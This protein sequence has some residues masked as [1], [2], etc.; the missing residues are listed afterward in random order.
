MDD[1]ILKETL[2]NSGKVEFKYE[3]R[4]K[5]SR[6]FT[7]DCMYLEYGQNVESVPKSVLNICFV[8][9][10][11]PLIWLT[12]TVLWVDE[13]DRTFYDCVLRLKNAYQELYPQ[14]QLKGRFVAAKTEY[15]SYNIQRESLLLFSGGID[16]HVSYLR[17]KESNPVLCNIQGWC[18]DTDETKKEA[19][20]ADY[21]DIKEFA[22][23][24]KTEFE[25]VTSNF[26][27]L[28]NNVE[29]KKNIQKKLGDSW[30]HAFQHSM[31]F[32]SI[33]MPLA[34]IY[35][36][37][38]IY[39]ASSFSIGNPGKCSSYATTDIEFK[40]ATNGGCIH[41]AF[42]MSRQKKVQY[43]VEYQK[44]SGKP[45]P[46]RVCSFNDK[47]C[48]ECEKCFRTILEIVAEGG[49][50][51]NFGF[52][53]EQPL[54]EHWIRV[55]KRNLYGFGVEGEK[56]KHWPD[57]IKRMKENY[58]EIQQKEFVDWFLNYDFV[59][60]KKKALLRYYKEN[61]W[62]IVKRKLIEYKNYKK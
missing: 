16:A 25:F 2:V 47:N 54:K 50:I 5:L 19:A 26:A 40:F 51:H 46:V 22:Q 28:I 43:I 55:F 58:A 14:Y 53:I 12:D 61:F 39:I 30:W 23:K 57:S 38:N 60:E 9:S 18:D 7:T 1:I 31:S 13:I 11:L 29:F 56:K 24:E 20:Q 41:D 8:A 33:A 3:A 59:G 27:T 15:N 6:Y 17:I 4:G 34:Y 32:I 42:D 36:I 10:V 21:R 37:K 62:S 48:C 45:Y 52:K 44:K 35:G 49:D